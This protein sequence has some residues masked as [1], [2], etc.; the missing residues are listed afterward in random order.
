[1]KIC[2]CNGL[3]KNC[4]GINMGTFFGQKFALKAKIRFSDKMVNC[5]PGTILHRQTTRRPNVWEE[6]LVWR[7]EEEF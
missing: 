3:I 7:P 4:P 6:Y 1:M 5:I 2:Y